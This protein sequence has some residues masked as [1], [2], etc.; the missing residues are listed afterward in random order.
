MEPYSHLYKPLQAYRAFLNFF[1]LVYF[2]AVPDT[3]QKALCF[4]VTPVGSFE[5]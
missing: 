3:T 5:L 1:G 2:G 4:G